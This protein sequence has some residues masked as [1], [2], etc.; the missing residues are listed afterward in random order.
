[1][2]TT[3]T[4]TSMTGLLELA[5]RI[6]IDIAI[7]SKRN[8]SSTRILMLESTANQSQGDTMRML[9]NLLRFVR[10]S[11]VRYS[12]NIQWRLYLS[13]RIP[14][15]AL[16]TNPS[17]PVR[18]LF[19]LHEA[20]L[21]VPQHHGA[22]P[23]TSPVQRACLVVCRRLHFPC[24]EFDS[25]TSSNAGHRRSRIGAR[26]GRSCGCSRQESCRQSACIADS[27]ASLARWLA[28][29]S[30]VPPHSARRGRAQREMRL[31]TWC[32]C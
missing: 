23:C 11:T 19:Q 20:V 15:T 28:G 31:C 21:S 5:E 4:T 10:P 24:A 25:G 12:C 22:P 7:D 17:S 30:A 29:G 6:W 3:M 2:K 27:F 32:M 26:I 16:P 9:I 13:K 1:M 14:S 8:T 18:A